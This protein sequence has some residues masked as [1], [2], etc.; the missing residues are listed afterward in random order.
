MRASSNSITS[1]GCELSWLTSRACTRPGTSSPSCGADLFRSA[2]DRL[3][4]LVPIVSQQSTLRP[5]SGHLGCSESG[6]Q[7]A[8][9]FIL[10]CHQ[11]VKQA[12]LFPASDDRME[13]TFLMMRREE[14][15]KAA[16]AARWSDQLFAVRRSSATYRS[17][18]HRKVA[19]PDLSPAL[20]LP[21]A[22]ATLD[23]VPRHA[24]PARNKPGF[25]RYAAKRPS[26]GASPSPPGRCC[27]SFWRVL[28]APRIPGRDRGEEAANEAAGGPRS[29]STVP[30]SAADCS[31]AATFGSL[32]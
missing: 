21:P 13:R 6:F 19:P 27:D 23:P 18:V 10:V 2:T 25:T 29:I 20:G 1:A 14:I 3:S 30:G 22:A 26:T 9:S 31:R 16:H 12:L 17:L 7:L 24:R 15:A 8:R 11:R 32:R 4:S 28:S 5:L